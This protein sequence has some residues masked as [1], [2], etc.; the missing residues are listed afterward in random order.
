MAV[1]VVGFAIWQFIESFRRRRPETLADAAQR[2]QQIME[3]L[4]RLGT[5]EGKEHK[6]LGQQIVRLIRDNC[7]TLM[8]LIDRV[9][10]AR[11]MRD[12]EAFR[13]S[14][15]ARWQA[16]GVYWRTNW[17]LFVFR[18]RPSLVRGCRIA[19][20]DRQH[21]ETWMAYFRFLRAQYPA[22]L[23]QLTIAEY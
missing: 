18:L 11:Q 2:G 21:G 16:L 20:I 23:G 7:D 6:E 12:E 22:E 15:D 5:L 10:Y 8:S 13:L 14:M 4:R 19:K 17:M 1:I 9:H 3:S